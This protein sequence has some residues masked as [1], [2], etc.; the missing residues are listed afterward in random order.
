M[1]KTLK[2]LE[3]NWNFLNL[4]KN[5]YKNF[6]ANIIFNGEKIN[7]PPKI[8]KKAKI[9]LSFITPIQHYTGSPS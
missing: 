3:I 6:T 1:I 5:I 8:R 9:S 7:D 4:I 2:K